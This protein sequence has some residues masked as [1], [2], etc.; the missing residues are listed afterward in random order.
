MLMGAS[1]FGQ[2][3][4]FLGKGGFLG[5]AGIGCPYCATPS[6]GISEYQSFPSGTSTTSC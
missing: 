1:L 6:T 3:P 5:K 2:P 4:E